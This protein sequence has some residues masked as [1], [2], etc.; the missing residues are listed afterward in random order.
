[1][2]N[3]TDTVT[4]EWMEACKGTVL[5]TVTVTGDMLADIE[6]LSVLTKYP[7]NEFRV[8]ATLNQ[9]TEDGYTWTLN[10]TRL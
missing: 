1:M 5:C 10:I 3:T 6:L 9:L 4:Q 7:L 8:T 2:R